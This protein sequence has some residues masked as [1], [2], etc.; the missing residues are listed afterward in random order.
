MKNKFRVGDIVI[1]KFKQKY[2]VCGT[3]GWV[4]NH[5]WISLTRDMGKIPLLD[6]ADE[7]KL[8]KK[9]ELITKNFWKIFPEGEK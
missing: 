5:C 1:N 6:R 8:F 7:Y 9:R 4:H 2:V 3:K